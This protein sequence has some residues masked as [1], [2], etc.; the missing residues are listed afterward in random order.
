MAE[1]KWVGPAGSGGANEVPTVADIT[2]KR[3]TALTAPQ[4]DSQ[5]SAA[6]TGYSLRTYVDAQDA[7]R[8]VKVYVDAQDGN[9]LLRTDRGI[10]N[11]P[12]PL[13]SNGLIPKENLT[14]TYPASR[15]AARAYYTPAGY[16][17]EQQG[18]T[19][20]DQV[21]MCS[22]ITIPDPGYRYKIVP[23][24]YWEVSAVANTQQ[25]WPEIRV[26]VG[27]TVIGWGRGGYNITEGNPCQ[28]VFYDPNDTVW[29]GAQTVTCW[30]GRNRWGTTAS[31]T[32]IWNTSNNPPKLWLLLVAARD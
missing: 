10:A 24:G 21:K 4:I 5:I 20:Q 22:D 14:N 25:A 16:T 12:V 3:A 18:L 28:I 31:S 29:T 2:T 26:K 11:G 17:A 1:L 19:G 13:D 23:F 8:A 27:S 9:K 6:L 32:N 7:A 15:N 30:G